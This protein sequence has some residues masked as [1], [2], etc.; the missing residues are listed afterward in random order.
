MGGSVQLKMDVHLEKNIAYF[1]KYT[2]ITCQMSV[3]VITVGSL[4][5]ELSFWSIA[6]VLIL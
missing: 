4:Q 5:L 2:Q 1:L 6:E 3:D